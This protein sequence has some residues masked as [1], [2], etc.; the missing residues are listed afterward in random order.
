M[1]K[2]LTIQLALEDLLVDLHFARKHEQLGRL[3]LLAYCD[4]KRWARLAGKADVA[5]MAV[6]MFACKPSPNREDFLRDIDQILASLQA[7]ETRYD[8]GVSA[9]S[10][11]GDISRQWAGLRSS[12][13]LLGRG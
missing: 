10:P 5:D 1:T 3:A 7:H 6:R 4:V 9:Q 13:V 12:E 2:Q 8:P 11:S